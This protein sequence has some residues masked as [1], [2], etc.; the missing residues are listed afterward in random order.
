LLFRK[1][2]GELEQKRGLRVARVDFKHKGQGWR[3]A[4]T[5]IY[6]GGGATYDDPN[7]SS[8]FM[9]AFLGNLCLRSSCHDCFA[10]EGVYADLL[11]GDYWGIDKAL[12]GFADDKGVSVVLTMSDK[13]RAA[14]SGVSDQLQ[15]RETPF[16]EAWRY[17][18]AL[19]RSSPYNPRREDFLARLP[20]EPLAELVNSLLP[21]PTARDK[22]RKLLKG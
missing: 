7:G 12:P 5:R 3:H 20:D 9:K 15:L 18:P 6:F 14:L 4:Q 21:Q 19:V 13:G 17:N 8:T 10:K 11:I 22:I 16:A 2:L 1:Y